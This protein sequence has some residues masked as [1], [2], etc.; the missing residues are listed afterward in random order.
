MYRYLQNVTTLRFDADRCSGCGT[1]ITV[2][3][4][5]VWRL[6]ERRAVID[7]RDACME[8]SACAVNCPEE[9]IGVRRGVG[10]ANAIILSAFGRQDE[11]CC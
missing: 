4:Q 1:C 11:G 5:R 8:C 10:C 7:D 3:P 6:Q 9:A 2:C